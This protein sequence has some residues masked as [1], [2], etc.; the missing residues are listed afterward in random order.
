MTTATISSG[1]EIQLPQDVLD[2]LAVKPGERVSIAKLPKGVISLRA[3]PSGDVSEFFGSLK[4][5][6]QR[7]LSLD[8]INDAGPEDWAGG[9]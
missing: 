6:G 9:M 2:H 4:R 8:E 1:G 5:D 7:P 3:A